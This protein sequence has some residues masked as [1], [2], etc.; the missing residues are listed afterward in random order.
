[1]KSLQVKLKIQ[2]AFLNVEI[3]NVSGSSVDIWDFN[4]PLGWN[5]L[6]FQIKSNSSGI[7]S[8]IKRK[9]RDWTGSARDTIKISPGNAYAIDLNI[10]DGWWELEENI[11]SF[12]KQSLEVEAIYNLPSAAD[13]K[14]TDIPTGEFI[15]NKVFS[16]PPH[17]WLFSG[18]QLQM[19]L[20]VKDRLFQLNFTN[21]SRNEIRIWDFDSAWGWKTLSFKIIAAGKTSFIERRD[22]SFAGNPAFIPLLPGKTIQHEIDINDGSW[23]FISEIQNPGEIA[24]EAMAIMDIP[25]YPETK[26]YKAFYGF[27]RSNAA[28]IEPSGSGIFKSELLT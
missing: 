2:D 15:S 23:H 6:S 16:N 4:S 7:I 28:I 14:N 25:V 8:Q 13:T 12:E 3:K 17:T 19:E 27:I 20:S 11:W 18:H 10:K 22:K 26:E 9:R 5:S 24:A 1:M 21:L